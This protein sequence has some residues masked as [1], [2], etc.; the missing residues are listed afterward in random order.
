MLFTIVFLNLSLAGDRNSYGQK[1]DYLINSTNVFETEQESQVQVISPGNSSIKPII[2]TGDVLFSGYKFPSIPDG[3]GVIANKEGLVDIFI[4][5]E[6]RINNVNEYAK[7]SKI[8]IDKEGKVI[9]GKLLKD[10]SGVYQALCSTTLVKDDTFANP[11]LLTNEEHD[12]GIVIAYD[13]ITETKTEMPWLGLFSHENTIIVPNTHN[14]TLVITSEDNKLDQSQLYAFISNNSD[15]LLEG[16]G[17]LYVL[18]GEDNNLSSFRDIQKGIQYNGYFEAVNWNWK[19][20]NSSDLENE[21]QQLNAIYFIKLEDIDFN[22]NDNSIFYIA[23]TGTDEAG[24]KYKNHFY[25]L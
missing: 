8:T 10:S 12:D 5:H 21:V 20:Q 7:I 23:D 22:K 24:D 16:N 11:L 13:I 6:L 25:F 3:I 14:K 15:E 17:Q 4:N 19:T 1:Y 2:T 9:F 18:T